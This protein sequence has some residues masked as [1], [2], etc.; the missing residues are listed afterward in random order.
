MLNFKQWTLCHLSLF[1][2]FIVS[3]LLINAIQLCL[4]CLI[5]WWNRS[6]FRKLNY[7]LVWMI[8]AQLLFLIDWWSNSEIRIHADPDIIEGMSKRSAI[9]LMNHHIE[10]DWLFGWM[11]ADR[12]KVL[13]NG[14]VFVK[15]MLKYVPIIGWAWN[16]SDIA[17]LERDWNKDQETMTKSVQSLA[18]YPDPVWLLLFA[19]GTRL[20]PEKLEASRDFARKR[21]LPVLRHCLTPRTKGFSFIMQQ[22]DRQVIP[23]VYD[24]TLAINSKD[25]GPATIS[26]ILLGRKTVGEIYIRRF[27][28]NEIP[29]TTDESAQYL[30]DVYKSKDALLDSYARTGTFTQDNQ[31]EDYKIT[32]IPRRIYSLL[33]TIFW[34]ILVIP[35]V[36]GQIG[37]SAVSGSMI[38]FGIVLFIVIGMYVALRKFIGLT[39]I[40]KA[41]S[42]GN[43]KTE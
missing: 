20:N 42:Y 39:K 17:Y 11:V 33:N 34:N 8:Y 15:K 29:K 3:G 2:S 40:S 21:G 4:Y 28:I 7:Y 16:F 35:F 23:Y 18:D 5:G 13:G 25:G 1:V 30:M 22:I 38:Q 12:S 19:E 14:R 31:F 27:D 37:A 26:S 41:S 24:V 43:K 32:V 36:F 10:L 9:V 6:L